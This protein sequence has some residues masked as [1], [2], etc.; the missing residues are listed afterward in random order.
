LP[1][2]A[3]R[4]CGEVVIDGLIGR[5]IEAVTAEAIEA[6]LRWA[7]DHPQALADMAARAPARLAT[8][9]PERVLDMLMAAVADVRL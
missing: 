7:L 4:H 2:F 5:P 3:S 8:Y 1:V 9:A 6:Q